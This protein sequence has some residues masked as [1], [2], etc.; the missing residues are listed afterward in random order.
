MKSVVLLLAVAGAVVLASWFLF[1]REVRP[2]SAVAPAPGE[3]AD[4]QARERLDALEAEVKELLAR[5]DRTRGGEEADAPREPAA[6]AAAAPAPRPSADLGGDAHAYL[7]RYV[8]SFRGGGTGS[9]Y[10][11]LAVDAYANELLDP[12]VALV[13]DGARPIE[14]RQKLIAMLGT[15]RFRGNWK[16]VGPL[17]ALVKREAD[18]AVPAVR[19]LVVIGDAECGRSLEGFACW[20]RASDVRRATYVAAV[21]LAAPEIDRAVLRLLPCVQEQEEARQLFALARGN[22]PDAALELFRAASAGEIPIRLVAAERIAEFRSAALQEFTRSWHGTEPDAEVRRRLERSMAKQGEKTRWSAEQAVGPPDANLAADDIRSWASQAA[23][24]GME[25]IELSFPPLRANA[26][27]VF[28]GLAGG[29]IAEVHGRDASGAWSVLWTG[30]QGDATP[31]EWRFEFATTAQPI[32]RVKLVLDTRRSTGWNEID[33]VEL[34][35]PD[36]ASWA[37]AAAASSYFGQ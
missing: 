22:D 35:G 30:T 7:D 6:S 33:A 4:R 1:S 26:V 9:E 36:G 16:V 28:E 24:G 18:S 13:S 32:V 19:A 3:A 17:V 11:R 14:L 20:I 12:I 25:W 29:A 2:E 37:T 8:E 10:F 21:S 31:G 27:R 5:I 15:V 34:A 23:D